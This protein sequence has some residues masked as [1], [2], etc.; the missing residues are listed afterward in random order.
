MKNGMKKLNFWLKKLNISTL[1]LLLLI[2]CKSTNEKI[3]IKYHY[4]ITN[5]RIESKYANRTEKDYL[6]IIP[7]RIPLDPILNNKIIRGQDGILHRIYA[8][9]IKSKLHIL[10]VDSEFSNFYEVLPLKRQS[11]AIIS[12]RVNESLNTEYNKYKIYIFN[13][14]DF[15][16]PIF[17][18]ELENF[19]HL[20]F[21]SFIPY[22]KH[23]CVKGDTIIIIK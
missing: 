14:D 12:Y 16:S 15:T 6:I 3:S 20:K 13:E 23:L 19:K 17:S 5:K 22:T 9:R 2:T 10:S 7:K 1:F 4:D 21:Q 11:E 18:K 8:N